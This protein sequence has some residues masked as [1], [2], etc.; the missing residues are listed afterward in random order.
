M[1]RLVDAALA[2]PRSA[3]RKSGLLSRMRKGVRGR[4]NDRFAL[5]HLEHRTL[6]SAGLPLQLP[7]IAFNNDGVM[8][9]DA[10]TDAFDVDADALSILQPPPTPITF[11]DFLISIAVDDSGAAT[12][13][14][15]D[16]LVVSGDVTVL[17]QPA[18][19]GTLL[20]GELVSFNSFDDSLV[21]DS[22]EFVF[23][24]TGGLLYTDAGFYGGQLVGVNLVS[25]S[26]SFA[27]SFLE[28]FGG[29]AK[30]NLGGLIPAQLGDYVW[31]DLNGDGIQDANE[32]GV[33]GVTVNLKDGD[34]NIIDT[35]TTDAD[36]LYLFDF[37][38]PGD[39]SVQ[40]ELP[41]G[42]EF[43]LQDQGLDDALDSDADPVSG[44]TQVV[45]LEA[46]DSNLTL[47]A[48]L[49]KEIGTGGDNAE[50]GDR[51]WHDL[52]GNGLQD[53]GEPGVNGVTVTLT[54]GGPDGVIGTGGD[55]TTAIAVT[56]G[57]GLYLFV[58]LNSGEEYK[59][60]FDLPVGF[61]FTTQD[62]DNPAS[63][64][65]DSDV[66]P[67]NGMTQIVTLLPNESNLTLD[68]GIL[69]TAALGDYVWEDLNGDGIQD[70]NEP[71]VEGV[72]VTLTGGGPDGIIGTAD[73]TT[74]TTT[75][76]VDGLYLFDDLNP[77]EEYKVTFS[78]L[79]AGFEF[80]TQDAGGDDALDSDADPGN[81]MTQIVTLASGEVNLTL[82]AGFVQK[83]I[84]IE[85]HVE[86]EDA[87]DE[88]SAVIVAPGQPITY[89]FFVENTG[90]MPFDFDDVIVTDDNGTPGDTGD[91]FTPDFDASSDVGGDMILSPGEV[92]RYFFETTAPTSGSGAPITIDFET[93][94][95]GNGLSAGTVIDDEYAAYGLTI[96]TDNPGPQPLMIFDT[97]NPTG[98]DTDLATPSSHPTNNVALGNVLIISEDG[99]SSDP[100]DDA[101]GGQII[102]DWDEPVTIDSVGILDIDQEPGGTIELFDSGSTLLGTFT[103]ADLGDGSFQEIV[104]DTEGVSQMVVTFPSSG[105]VSEVVFR[106]A[107]DGCFVNNVTVDAMGATDEDPAYI[108]LET[109][110]PGIDIEKLT[111]G[112]DADD[113]ADAPE[114]PAGSTVTW[115]YIVTNTGDVPFSESEVVIVDDAGTPGDSS[116][117]FSTTSGDIVLDG[118]SDVGGDLILSPGE[119]WT[120]TATGVAEDLTVPGDIFQFVFSGNSGL[121]GPDGNIRTFTANGVSVNASAFSRSLEGDWS[122]AFLGSFSSGLGVTDST[123]GNGGNGLHR[124]DNVGQY[125]FVL[126]EFSES[127]VVD[128]VFLDSVVNDSDMSAWIATTS[129]PFNDH[130]TLSDSFLL[131]T[132]WVEVNNTGSSSSRWANI[133]ANEVSGNILVVAASLDDPTPEDR[134]KVR[135]LKVKTTVDDCY[136]NY[137]V[138]TVPGATDSDLSH[139]CN[140]EDTNPDISIEKKTNGVDADTPGEA[141]EL[142]PGDDITWTYEVTN[143]GDVPFAEVDVEVVDDNGTPGDTSDDITPVLVAS[144]DVGGD[145]ILSPNEVWT[146][147]AFG[148]AQALPGGATG[149]AITVH[150]DGSSSLDGPDGNIRTFDA[151]GVS[152]N[153][154]AFSRDETSGDWSEAWLGIFGG[155]LGVTDSSEGDGSGNSHTVD[156]IGRDNYV[157]FEFSET[158]VIDEAFLGF[159]NEDSDLTAWIGT[160]NDPFNNHLTLSDGLLTSLGFT[161]DNN[162]SSDSSRW[163]D[164]NAG[165]VA[166][167]VL[168]IAASTS[169]DTPNDKFKIEKVKFQKTE[170]GLYAN[171]GTVDVPGA[172]DS[173]MSHY[174]NPI[175]PATGAIGDLVWKDLDKDGKQDADE[176]GIAGVTV[177]LLDTSDQVIGQTVTNENGEYEFTGLAAGAYKLKVVE[178]EGFDLSP[179]DQGGN[180]GTDSD[181]DPNTGVTG[182]ITLEAGEVNN[183]VDFG[184]GIHDPAMIMFEAEDYH[185][186]SSS[187]L[188]KRSSSASG[189]EYIV[190]TGGDH[191][192]GPG[193]GDYVKYNF[194]VTHAAE[195][196]LQALVKAVSGSKNSVW[197]KVDDGEW[198]EWHFDV[199]GHAWV[200]QSASDGMQQVP[201][202]FDFDAGWH[203]MKIKIREDGTKIDKFKFVE[204]S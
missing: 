32:P 131:S 52:N 188:T 144:S 123:E 121:D 50:L 175:A 161:E 143:T 166:G 92:W 21:T 113:E 179:Q 204:T 54:G 68:A 44:M 201:V 43:T 107:E 87:D 132:P 66:D 106:P 186:A 59:V 136:E 11:G 27:G 48:G 151:G 13:L 117:D 141:V 9:Y 140:P 167:N 64:E 162:T 41:D 133:N 61:E 116:D 119:Q 137:A 165:G 202:T 178:P 100:D 79:P 130:I 134:F 80:T 34:G 95:V 190:G 98:G 170:Q 191:Y 138:V 25:E 58:D 45:T 17:G 78:D 154:S 35:T 71:G 150:F 53:D 49:I 38:P 99:D 10:T 60:T 23:E 89:E 182:T 84:D 16:D 102:F 177:K 63:D 70:A 199:T 192:N 159:V 46:G 57:D 184:L 153:A 6:L 135:K 124:V 195:Y 152:V 193:R 28:N 109:P 194:E 110:N 22:Y 1:N 198:I 112:V 145:G 85:K 158:V 67:S 62:V 197:L 33:E 200:W 74:E 36:G 157:L 168:V 24:P 173:D 163:A 174:T 125:N 5:E 77:G 122:D 30:G 7:L 55:D 42:F 88:A 81:G 14:P 104:T 12:S 75:T 83:G 189:G 101:G 147:E 108:C 82:D 73:D 76:D 172:N 93:D 37:L 86:G 169:D 155:G 20:T 129:D 4:R 149:S 31:E 148:T 142:A 103:M 181:A 69:Q 120:F 105:A 183:T 51:L 176:P 126:F 180:D 39:Y 96:S 187:W 2:W 26:S 15:G 47:D 171:K 3:F 196:E 8:T 91:D 111:N 128:R 203:T 146:Y 18:F 164:L 19:S 40:F 94:G 29:D 97:A 72:T 56:S 139:Y 65:I 118:A 90:S 114:I 156:N 127:V 115:T 185:R 160:R